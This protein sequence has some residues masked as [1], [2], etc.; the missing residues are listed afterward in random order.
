MKS[1]G[2]NPH[3]KQVLTRELIEWADYVFVMSDWH[4]ERVLELAPSASG[5]TAVIDVP[6]TYLRNDPALTGLLIERLEA[7]SWKKGRNWRFSSR[8]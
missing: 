5:K 8:P 3:S 1:C 6:D 7:W 2:V 4:A